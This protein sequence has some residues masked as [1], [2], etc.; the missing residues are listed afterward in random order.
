[1]SLGVRLCLG[2]RCRNRA[3]QAR[4]QCVGSWRDRCVDIAS[5]RKAM[6]CGRVE[7]RSSIER[8]RQRYKQLAVLRGKDFSCHGGKMET[9]VSSTAGVCHDGEAI[10]TLTAR[11]LD[12]APNLAAVFAAG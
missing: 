7:E 9:G 10:V 2:E 5:Q 8:C 11:L 1:M 6:Q 4:R 3:I 12:P